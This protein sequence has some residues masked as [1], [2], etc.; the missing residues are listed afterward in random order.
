MTVFMA[1]AP[2]DFLAKA[3]GA[4]AP[5]AFLKYLFLRE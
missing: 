1:K 5:P 3:G 2:Q 4:H